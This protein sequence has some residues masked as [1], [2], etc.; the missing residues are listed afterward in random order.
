MPC[1]YCQTFGSG[2]T[3]LLGKLAG[4]LVTVGVSCVRGGQVLRRRTHVMCVRERGREREMERYREIDKWRE[5][6]RQSG[7]PE[8]NQGPSDCC[9]DLQSDALPTEL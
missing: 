6:D 5:T 2:R 1:G 9:S 4:N 3:L 8:S 7:H